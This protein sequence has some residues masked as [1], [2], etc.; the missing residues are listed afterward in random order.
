VIA[1]VGRLDEGGAVAIARAASARAAAVPTAVPAAAA[2]LI[3][4][5]PVGAVGDH[6]LVELAEAGIGHAAALRSP[7]ADLDPGDLQ[8]ALRYLPDVHV[9]VLAGDDPG[10]QT[11]AAEAA[12]WSNAALIVIRASSDPIDAV[13]PD[14][15]VLEAPASDPD[16]AFAGVVAALAIRLDAGDAPSAAWR[17]VTAEL[18]VDAV[19]R[20]S[21]QTG[22][23]RSG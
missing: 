17:A 6:R 9:I 11:T 18:G 15:I 7:A 23:A 3:T 10:L 16:G 8:L 13:T 12:A 5:V 2:Q 21:G 19:S 14:A 22:T 1:V 4:T 20:T